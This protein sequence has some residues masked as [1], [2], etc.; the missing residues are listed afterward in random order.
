MLVE[1]LWRLCFFQPE[2]RIV[3]K[4]QPE[5]T[6]PKTSAARRKKIIVAMARGFAVDWWRIRSGRCTAQEL[7]LKLSDCAQT[8]SSTQPQSK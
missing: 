5:L 4:W 2:Y 6:N 8:S 7:G 1:C 3:K